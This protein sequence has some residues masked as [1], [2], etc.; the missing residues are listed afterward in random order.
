MKRRRDG[1]L[2]EMRR[3]ELQHALVYG[4]NR[5]GSPMQWL[6]GW[7][8]TREAIAIVSEGH[9]DILLVQFYNHVPNAR[10]IAP[11][12]DVRWG[13]ESTIAT[14]L[15]I[16]K[17]R[18]LEDDRLGL[19]GPL[20]FHDYNRCLSACKEVVDLNNWYK[21]TRTVKAEE[22]IDWMRMGAEL[23]DR[24]LEALRE[25]VRPG[26]NERDLAD[27]VERAYVSRGGANHIHFFGVTDM[28]QP[29]SCVPAQFPS[30]RTVGRGDALVT[31]LSTSFWGYPGQVLRTFAIGERPT[32]LYRELHEVADGAFDAIT[33]RIRDGVHAREIID[34]ASLITDAGFAV[35]DDLVHGFG[36]DHLPSILVRRGDIDWSVADFTFRSGMTIVV[37]PNVITVDRKAGVQTGELLLVTEAGVESL[38]RQ[39]RGLQTL[40]AG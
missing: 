28:R 4:A 1:V 36:G 39:E 32:S 2:D 35:Y 15:S 21:R 16:L 18:R 23:T 9:D 22:E 5:L 33:R 38:H 14:A 7:P 10:E 6:S 11:D 20:P 31:E 13:G 25:H 12:L 26:I 30:T 34:A 19:I 3:R 8:A 17:E 24:S 37:Q 40:G 27:I 29:T